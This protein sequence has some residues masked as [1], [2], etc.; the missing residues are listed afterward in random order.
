MRGKRVKMLR[1]LFNMMHAGEGNGNQW[2]W[3]KRNWTRHYS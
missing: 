3:M 1:R 2:R